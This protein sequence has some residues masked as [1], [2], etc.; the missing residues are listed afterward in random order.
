LQ[1]I[2]CKLKDIRRQSH[3]RLT[4]EIISQ[5]IE[6]YVEEMPFK[7]LQKRAKKTTRNKKGK[8]N[9]KKRFGKSLANKAPASF[10]TILSNKLIYQGAELHMIKTAEVKASQYNHLTDS[11]EKKKLSERWAMIGEDK[12]QQDLYSSFLIMNV[13]PDLSSINREQCLKKYKKFKAMHDMEIE[14]LKTSTDRKLSS[15]GL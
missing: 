6:V 12:I 8:F 1:R 3:N 13:N 2:Q 15:M 14:K 4:N 9:S 5:G 10:L 7:G 11:Y